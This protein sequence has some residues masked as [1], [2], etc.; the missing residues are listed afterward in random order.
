MANFSH[1]WVIWPAESRQ[2]LLICVSVGA[3]GGIQST[4]AEAIATLEQRTLL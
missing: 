3:K 1:W 4:C 2:F